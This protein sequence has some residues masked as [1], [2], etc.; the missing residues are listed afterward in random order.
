MARGLR[1][2][3]VSLESTPGGN[4]VAGLLLSGNAL[5][6]TAELGGG[7]GNGEVFRIYADG[8][9]FTNL[10]FFSGG[11]GGASPQAGLVLSGDTLF[12]TT[13]LGGGTG[14]GGNGIVFAISTNGTG[15]TNLHTFNGSND[16]AYLQ[17]GLVVSG[18]TLYGTAEAGGLGPKG[19]SGTVFSLK[20]NGASFTVLHSFSA[21]ATNSATN[22]DGANPSAT[23]ILSGGTLYGTTDIGGTYGTGTVFS[24]DTNGSNFMSLHSLTGVL[25]GSDPQGGLVLGVDAVYGT[26]EF[27]GRDGS[28]I[29]FK[30]TVGSTSASP[31][32]ITGAGMS[33][34][35]LT[36]TGSDGESGGTYMILASTDVGLPL[37]QW[38]PVSTTVLTVNGD[39]TIS[40]TNVLNHSFP[41]RYFVLKG[42]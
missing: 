20:T 37:S 18:D 19:G 14:N 10:H 2:F 40:V 27:Y 26:A 15:F 17:A 34:T 25:D 13:S 22:S 36:I 31:P 30:L 32:V 33:G 8:T 39:F 7:S 24:I 5:Y 21:T 6:G 42:P 41:Q 11:K 38:T 35:N 1:T 9:G 16:G 28:G 12:G 29:V 4:P 23:L 3:I